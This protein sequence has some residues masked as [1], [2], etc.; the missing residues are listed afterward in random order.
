M[1]Q[2]LKIKFHIDAITGKKQYHDEQSKKSQYPVEHLSDKLSE[3]VELS[4][5]PECQSSNKILNQLIQVCY[6]IMIYLVSAIFSTTL[7]NVISDF[8]C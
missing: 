6:S 8:K 2:H 3:K 5:D 1:E 4:N 7:N